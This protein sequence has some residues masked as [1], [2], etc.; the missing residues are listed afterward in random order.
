MVTTPRYTEP[1][2]LKWLTSCHVNLPSVN[3]PPPNSPNLLTCS[4]NVHHLHSVANLLRGAR[5]AS[6]GWKGGQLLRG[7]AAAGQHP[8]QWEG[9]LL[10][11]RAPCSPRYSE[12]ENSSLVTQYHLATPAVLLETWVSTLSYHQGLGPVTGLAVC[13]CWWCRWVSTPPHS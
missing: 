2:T 11:P 4:S 1:Y 8:S 6:P 9:P 7:P 12:Q 3:C 13:C 10:P 5:G